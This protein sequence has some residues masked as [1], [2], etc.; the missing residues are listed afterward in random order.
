MKVAI[1]ACSPDSFMDSE[2][3]EVTPE[4]TFKAL[5]RADALGREFKKHNIQ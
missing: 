5:M 4:M 1:A 3:F 2:P